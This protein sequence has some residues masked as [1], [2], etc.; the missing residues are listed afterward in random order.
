MGWLVLVV[1]GVVLWWWSL[2]LTLA[3][4]QGE[5]MPMWTAAAKAPRRAIALRAVGAAAVV[6]GTGM[7]AAVWGQP[8]W[9]AAVAAGA[10]VSLTL[11]AP[12]LVDVARH[13]S[14]VASPA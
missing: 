2:A 12:H 5:R 10:F 13:N 1:V 7:F 6:F 3:A 14:D 4:Y 8:G 11:V 9:V